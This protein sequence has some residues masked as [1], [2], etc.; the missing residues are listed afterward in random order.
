MVGYS[1]AELMQR[2]ATCDF[3]HGP[4]TSS[5]ATAQIRESLSTCLEK[6]L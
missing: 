2:P 6:Q 4:L 3:L 1:R 5:Q